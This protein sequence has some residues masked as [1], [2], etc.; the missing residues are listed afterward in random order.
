MDKFPDMNAE[1]WT[2]DDVN[3]FASEYQL[4]VSVEYQET[5][6]YEEGKVISQSRPA[7]SS[8]YKGTSLRIVVAKKP[9]EKKPEN[10]SGGNND[11][12]DDSTDKEP[13]SDK[14]KKSN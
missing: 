5:T 13:S 4:N 6:Q 2:I 11:E 8:I 10:P 14:D 7:G 9:E 12:S 1:G 3:A